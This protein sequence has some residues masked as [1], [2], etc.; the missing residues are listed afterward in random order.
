[1]SRPEVLVRGQRQRQEHR[2]TNGVGRSNMGTNAHVNFFCFYLLSEIEKEVRKCGC[3]LMRAG[4]LFLVAIVPWCQIQC[5][6]GTH[7]WM[8]HWILNWLFKTGKL[9]QDLKL[10]SLILNGLQPDAQCHSNIPVVTAVEFQGC[11]SQQVTSG[12]SVPCSSVSRYWVEKE[13][14][15]GLLENDQFYLI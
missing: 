15:S 12:K 7:W 6:K 3:K 5:S 14:S 8:N 2:H 10:V 13:P 11:L 1:M 4:N 9:S